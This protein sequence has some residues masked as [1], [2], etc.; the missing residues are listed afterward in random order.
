MFLRGAG[1]GVKWGRYPCH[2]ALAGLKY[3]RGF[4]ENG[5]GGDAGRVQVGRSKEGRFLKIRELLP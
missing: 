1:S 4:G 2:T 5:T 3:R